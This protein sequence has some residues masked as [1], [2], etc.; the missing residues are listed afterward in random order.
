[1]GILGK[2]TASPASSS[3]KDLCC[4]LLHYAAKTDSCQKGVK[5]DSLTKG[6][7]PLSPPIPCN[8][9]QEREIGSLEGDWEQLLAAGACWDDV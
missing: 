8:C 6:L 3:L 9:Q 1:V 5:S 7:P 2:V 4:C